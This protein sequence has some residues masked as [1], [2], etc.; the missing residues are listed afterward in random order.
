LA[1][2]P[3]EIPTA[4]RKLLTW[5]TFDE[6]DGDTMNDSSGNSH[7]GTL[8][9][10]PEWQPDG[11]KVGGALA[12]DGVDDY[13]D[14]GSHEDLNL[15]NA[16]SI[17]AWIKL[18]D[19][20]QD[21]KIAGNQ[22]NRNGGF[23]LGIYENKPEM[24][25]RD[26]GNRLSTNRFIEGGTDFEPDTWYHIVG[27][28]SQGASI[29]TYVNGKLDREM[30][31]PGILAPSTGALKI[32]CEPFLDSYWFKGLMDD[33]RIYSYPLAETEVAALYA[34]KAPTVVAQG[35]VATVSP[36]EP[37]KTSHWIPLTVIA[38]LVL[39]VGAFVVRKQKPTT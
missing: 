5:W 36:E 23:K 34:G 24:E 1:L 35:P 4:E 31:S 26:S 30:T 37:K 12:F 7:S 20:A 2:A 16:V 19:P 22:D 27:I 39:A 38:A 28:Y 11:G 8:V 10:G 21:Q 25:I 32:G 9:G 3:I 29:K 15:T 13:V 33:L 18:A 14:C 6:T 17:S